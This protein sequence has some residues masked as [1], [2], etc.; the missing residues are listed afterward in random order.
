MGITF[1]KNSS[2]CG[3]NLFSC[4]LD[5]LPRWSFTAAQRAILVVADEYGKLATGWL[6]LNVTLY[7]AALFVVGSGE[8]NNQQH[9]RRNRQET[10]RLRKPPRVAS[11]LRATRYLTNPD[12]RP[13]PGSPRSKKTC[14]MGRLPCS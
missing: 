6:T 4:F 12:P 8:G 7:H 10:A 13:A 1:E 2:C 11:G 9:Q 5:R 3:P 14:R